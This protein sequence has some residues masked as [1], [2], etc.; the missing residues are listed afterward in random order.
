[1]PPKAVAAADKKGAA[2]KEGWKSTGEE[3]GVKVFLR[4]RPFNRKEMEEMGGK[5]AK[6]LAKEASADG[7]DCVAHEKLQSESI[8]LN[9]GPTSCT[10]A[11][12]TKAD[13]L[14]KADAKTEGLFHFDRIFD[15]TVPGTASQEEIFQTIGPDLLEAS[16]RGYNVCLMAYGQTSSGKTYTMT[17]G[18]DFKSN[19]KRG[20]IPR[21]LDG[22]FSRMQSKEATSGTVH[23]KLEAAYIEIYNEQ[24]KDLLSSAA[25][26]KRLQVREHPERGPFA[27]GLKW[28]QILSPGAIHQVL[29]SGNKMRHTRAT[30]MNDVSS[31]SHAILQLQLTQYVT[32]EGEAGGE[33][34]PVTATIVSKINLVD[35]A[36]SERQKQTQSDGSGLKEAIHINSALHCL[37]KVIDALTQKSAKNRPQAGAL[38]SLQRESI[39]TWLLADS[40][41]GN[42]KTVLVATVSPSSSNYTETLSTLK[43]ASAARE[44]ENTV[45]V[46]SDGQTAVIVALEDEVTRL[47]RALKEAEEHAR[48]Q[49]QIDDAIEEQERLRLMLETQQMERLDERE[50]MDKELTEMEAEMQRHRAAAGEEKARL[51]EEMEQQL[52]D[53]EAQKAALQAEVSG[54]QNSEGSLA[55]QL[56]ALKDQLR[57]AKTDQSDN[58]KH[59]NELFAE[60]TNVRHE[61]EGN[62]QQLQTM[63]REYTRNLERM[64]KGQPQWEKLMKDATKAAKSKGGGPGD[65]VLVELYFTRLQNLAQQETM[66]SMNNALTSAYK[67]NARM[68]SVLKGMG[69]RIVTYENQA[70][71]DKEKDGTIRRLQELMEIANA[72]EEKYLGQLKDLSLEH[73]ML[74]LKA[75]GLGDRAP[76]LAEGTDM[77]REIVEMPEELRQACDFFGFRD[78]AVFAKWVVKTLGYTPTPSGEQGGRSRASSVCDAPDG[79]SSGTIAKKRA[80]AQQQDVHV[81]NPAFTSEG[82]LSL[83]ST[84][85]I[86]PERMREILLEQE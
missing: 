86:P 5:D 84:G 4:V 70:F 24:V 73:L 49:K 65:P 62:Q 61:A 60:I 41:G 13:N 38:R 25:R 15:S 76:P 40:L 10:I 45:K 85:Y 12:P 74:S 34:G 56:E 7:V 80:A 2:D 31:R 69:D 79:G 36:G 55:S 17:G 52:R 78:P 29:E 46:N 9:K 50:D 44:I 64:V 20:I 68:A 63:Q 83:R 26:S 32:E 48:N 81:T 3:C 57:A 27:E 39:L 22:L 19:L 11:K 42:S 47:T 35:L 75:E 30:K 51:R 23:F 53:L 58:V 82:A 43:Y 16:T 66:E 54:F 37:R 71:N 33:E 67:E 21:F 1:M 6:G 18:E 14:T 28:K 8:V 59:Q 77:K 72:K